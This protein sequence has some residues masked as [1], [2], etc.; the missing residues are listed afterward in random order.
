MGEPQARNS[1]ELRCWRGCVETLFAN[2]IPVHLIFKPLYSSRALFFS[3]PGAVK[4]QYRPSGSLTRGSLTR[5]AWAHPDLERHGHLT[6]HAVHV[7]PTGR[8]RV[9]HPHPLELVQW[10]SRRPRWSWPIGQ[11]GRD[12]SRQLLRPE[13]RTRTTRAGRR[14]KAWTR[15][16]P[17]RRQEPLGTDRRVPEL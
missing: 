3:C 2:G 1:R 7:R 6:G 16:G 11:G 8:R 9:G 5:G 12:L 14:H 15:P 10:P 13:C 4:T 17:R